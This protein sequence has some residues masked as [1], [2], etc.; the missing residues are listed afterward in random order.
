MFQN[1]VKVTLLAV[2]A[3][4]MLALSGCGGGSSTTA[5]AP[6]DPTPPEPMPVTTPV[7]LGG[8]DAEA[9]AGTADIAAGMSGDIGDITFTCPAGG[10]DCSVTVNADG[11]AMSTGGMATAANSE[12]YNTRVAA[13]IEAMTEAAGTK[14]KAIAAEAAQ[15][16]DDTLGG[17]G[18]PNDGFDETSGN[19]DDELEYALSIKRDRTGTTVEIGTPTTG[20]GGTQGVAEPEFVQAPDDLGEGNTMHTRTMAADAKGNVVQEVVIVSTDIEAP[21]A[22]A[23]ALFKDAA[24][25]STQEL[26]IRKDGEPE[27]RGN[28]ND[29]LTLDTTGTVNT[30]SLNP[31]DAGVTTSVHTLIKSDAFTA[32]PGGSGTRTFAGDDPADDDDAAFTARG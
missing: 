24:G 10:E 6:V 11:T 7:D 18:I 3:A 21:K 16:T 25:M 31:A 14:E 29:S 12:A 8:V 27:T 5:P 13:A 23:F 17:S 20:T 22:V 32:G 9:T 19:A 30:I 28:P 1:R 15:T 4:F 26:N 2:L